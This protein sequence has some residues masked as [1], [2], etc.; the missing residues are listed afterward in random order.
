[1]IL[2]FWCK[3]R[4]KATLFTSV[5]PQMK[6]RR[7]P[8]SCQ[9]PG[10]YH[11]LQYFY[12]FLT[13]CLLLFLYSD[14]TFNCICYVIFNGYTYAES[15][16]EFILSNHRTKVRSICTQYASNDR[17]LQSGKNTLR[18]FDRELAG[19]QILLLIFTRCKLSTR[20]EESKTTNE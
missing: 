16:W 18:L 3:Y 12:A 11:L 8:S 2:Y 1:M 15:L 20:N 6:K 7:N 13:V 10:I 5:M 4:K 9:V 14:Q 17:L 19:H